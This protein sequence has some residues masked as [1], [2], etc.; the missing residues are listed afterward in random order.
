MICSAEYLFLA[1]LP[2][3]LINRFLT[4]TLT[5]QMD[6]LSGGRS[7]RTIANPVADYLMSLSFL[8]LN[9]IE[10]CCIFLAVALASLPYCHR[11]LAGQDGPT[12]CG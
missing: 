3:P 8:V 12:P 2:S 9:K 7:P 10:G 11:P 1:I 5:S 4:Q 6:Q